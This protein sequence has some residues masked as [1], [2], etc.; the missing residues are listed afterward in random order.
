MEYVGQRFAARTFDVSIAERTR[1]EIRLSI[2]RGTGRSAKAVILTLVSALA[3]I[4]CIAAVWPYADSRENRRILV[5]LWLGVWIAVAGISS[6]Q[7]RIP[8]AGKVS[9]WILVAPLGYVSAFFLVANE[10]P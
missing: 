10:L 8:F 1:R 9:L 5:V 6:F 7:E 2:R 3:W 4:L